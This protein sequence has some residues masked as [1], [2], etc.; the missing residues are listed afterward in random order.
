MGACREAV[1]SVTNE[2]RRIFV[3]VEFSYA[4]WI[5]LAILALWPFIRTYRLR[6]LRQR[7]NLNLPI[8][9]NE[10][11]GIAETI[12]N[13]TSDKLTVAE[14]STYGAVTAAEV[15]WSWATISPDVI[16]AADFSS[17][18]DIHNGYQFAEYLHNNFDTLGASAKEGF[19]NHLLG[20][21]GEQKVAGILMRQGHVVQMAE[22]ANQPVWDLY[23][24]GHAVNVKTVADISSIKAEAATH[25]GVLYLVPD[26]AHGQASGNIAHLSEFNHR[27]A[28]A[29]LHHALSAAHG[30]TA[31]H[32]LF[33][34]L[35]LVTIGF[36]AY[37]NIKGIQQG[38]DP[39]VA[40]H[41]GLAES[42]GRG[43]GALAGLQGGAA[44]GA[45]FGPHGVLIGGIIGAVSGGFLGGKAADAY[46]KIPLRKAQERFERDLH[47]FGC[48]FKD[49]ISEIY[50]YANAPL[51]R[52]HSALN[53]LREEIARRKKTI[54]WILWP[55]FYTV[56]LDE[57]ANSGSNQVSITNNDVACVKRILDQAQR[58]G[59][60]I[61]V[62][63]MM[64]NSPAVREL[65][66]FN[67][68][69]LEQVKR[70]RQKLFYQRK[71]DNPKF[72]VP[73]EN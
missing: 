22:T 5:I 16:Q 73:D 46:K 30:E 25:P 51:V 6:L 15:V 9:S 61:R 57:A 71:Q 11:K 70:S 32:S 7:A 63:V 17:S 48:E 69:T 3:S 58:S 10:R 54:R 37:R 72:L 43:G 21:V 52:M 35:P 42:V 12:S 36:A 23:V 4:C 47:I 60:Y 67:E 41:H 38:K 55:D 8:G 1:Q 53:K 50:G 28:Q 65:I 33:H 64:A 2:G 62:G 29:N 66:G 31:V 27:A 18:Y 14:L 20:Y 19:L 68:N 34:H 24:D 44:A 40:F 13:L 45:I 49:H 56:L 39:A 26:D 59:S